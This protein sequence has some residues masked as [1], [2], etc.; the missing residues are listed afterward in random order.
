MTKLNIKHLL[1]GL[2]LILVLSLSDQPRAIAQESGRVGLVV[3]FDEETVL[4]GCLDIGG[5]DL[6]GQ[7]ILQLSGLDL[8]LYYDASQEVAV[9]RVNE[10]GC[11]SDQCFCQFPDYWS[12]WHTE[13]NEWVYS[14]R[15]ASTHMSQSGTVEG[16]RWGSGVPPLQIS[17]EQI[18]SSSVQGDHAAPIGGGGREE[19]GIQLLPLK[20][21]ANLPDSGLDSQ[22]SSA[23]A[24]SPDSLGY[25]VF[26]A[27]L[28]SMGVGF[29]LILKKRRG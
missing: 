5:Q 21:G 13:G 14:G 26:G 17:F 12:Y 28:V 22:I 11:E 1:I 18:C 10:L 9:C 19:P 25:L 15:G 20:P 4:A 8:D 16:W 7:D 2:G 24:Q 23:P 3:Q 29:L 6:S 27:A